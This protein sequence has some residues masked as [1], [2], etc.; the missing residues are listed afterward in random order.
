MPEDEILAML[1]VQ[2]LC[3]CVVKAARDRGLETLLHLGVLKKAG[4][5]T[6]EAQGN[7]IIYRLT[8]DGEAWARRVAGDAED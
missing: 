3:V 4:L 6:G 5:I 2:P 1:A 7:R 8:A